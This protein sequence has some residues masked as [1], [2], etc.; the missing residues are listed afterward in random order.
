MEE[1][2]NRA[3]DLALSALLGDG[4]YNFGELVSKQNSTP[5]FYVI[6]ECLLLFS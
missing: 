3:H 4:L 1:Q 2:V 5:S 6:I